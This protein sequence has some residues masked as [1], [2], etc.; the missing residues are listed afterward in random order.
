MSIDFVIYVTPIL[1]LQLRLSNFIKSRV[2]G[3]INN[4]TKT[5]EDDSCF[6]NYIKPRN[7]KY[8]GNGN[9]ANI[10]LVCL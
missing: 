2:A 6:V 5:G 10:F 8:E 4:W 9:S 7:Y 3:E 1:A